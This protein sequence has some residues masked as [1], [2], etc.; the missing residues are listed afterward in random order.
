MRGVIL[1][2]SNVA[3]WHT[4]RPAFARLCG[5]RRYC[6]MA[7]RMSV[8]RTPNSWAMTFQRYTN[9]HFICF[10]SFFILFRVIWGHSHSGHIDLSGPAR[11]PFRPTALG[12]TRRIST[13][14]FPWPKRSDVATTGPR[15]AIQCRSSFVC[16]WNLCEEHDISTRRHAD[17]EFHHH[18]ARWRVRVCARKL[19]Q[20]RRR[21]PHNARLLGKVCATLN[22]K[23]LRNA[24]KIN[25]KK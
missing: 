17:A 11:C 25:C 7:R 1:I 23:C 22:Q 6:R 2:L 8:W 9:V 10:S 14:T 4:R 19:W 12:C 3:V 5:M 24:I 13:R 18:R 16:R 15:N 21:H 20:H